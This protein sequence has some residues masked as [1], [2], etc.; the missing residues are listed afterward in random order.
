MNGAGRR[1]EAARVS[2][3]GADPRSLGQ[4]VGQFL[5]H[6]GP[7]GFASLTVMV[8]LI[9]LGVLAPYIAPYD[10]VMP[11]V[12]SRLS[13]P[14]AGHLFGTDHLGRDILSRLLFGARVTYAVGLA[15]AAIA[16][17]IGVPLGLLA[18]YCGGW[19]DR[20]SSAIIDVLF[21]FPTVLLAVALVAVVGPSAAT[22]AVVLGV[23]VAPTFARIVR[24]V[25][26]S[27]KALPYVEAAHAAG[28]TSTRVLLRHVVPA[29]TGPVVA[30]LCLTISYAVIVESSLSYIGLGVRP[31]APSW[32]GMLLD[33]YGYLDRAPWGSLF[34]G[35]AIVLSVVSA[36]LAG[37]A[38]LSVF[39]PGHRAGRRRRRTRLL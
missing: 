21:A 7:V 12:R 6:L 38:L 16:A 9:L 4:R 28:A 23:L 25:V 19:Y 36:N 27:T 10:P 22:I 13:P 26:L 8:G 34:P 20:I 29:T 17:L 35:L 31:P 11:D 37:D 24:A 5:A 15:S 33:L 14:S 3:T 39:V 30:Q 2:A 18:G 1:G 32:G